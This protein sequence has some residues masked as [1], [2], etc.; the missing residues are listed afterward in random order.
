M[1]ALPLGALVVIAVVTG[2]A[3]G[4][5][6]IARYGVEDNT[7]VWTGTCS[8]KAEDGSSG[9][10]VTCNGV[11]ETIGDSSML[12]SI[13]RHPG[14]MPNCTLYKNNNILCESVKVITQ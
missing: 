7:E 1:K 5:S 6:N 4:A 2:I 8:Y 9:V 13:I 12:A 10:A 3:Y 11:T 14:V